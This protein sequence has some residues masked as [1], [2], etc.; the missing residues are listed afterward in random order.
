MI[1]KIKKIISDILATLGRELSGSAL[2]IT[3]IINDIKKKKYYIK[4]FIT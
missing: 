1:S 3:F 2:K 4:D